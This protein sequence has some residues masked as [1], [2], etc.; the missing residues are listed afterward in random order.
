M[1]IRHYLFIGL[2]LWALSSCS[3]ADEED[4]EWANWKQRNELYFEEQYAGHYVETSTSFV[5]PSW[6]MPNETT[7]DL[8]HTSYIL[9]DVIESAVGGDDELSPLYSDSVSVNY[10]GRLMPSDSYP[11]GYE[12]DRSWL[13]VYDP[14]VDVPYTVAVNGVVE[15]FSTAL[16]YMHRGDKWRV[17]MPYQLGYGS[18]DRSGIPAYST[19]VFEIELIDFWSKKK[20]DRL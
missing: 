10:S 2:S 20:G 11:Q 1:N 3:E 13:N 18:T 5:I 15:G 7:A 19:L 14:D 9:V 6:G 16:Q 17:T 8:P 12:F 4:P